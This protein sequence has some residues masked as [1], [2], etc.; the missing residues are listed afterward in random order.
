[1]R[2]KTTTPPIVLKK[3][4]NCPPRSKIGRKAA[5]VV[6]TPKITGTDTSIVPSIAASSF[7][8]PFTSNAWMRSPTTI[9]SST[10]IPNTK[11][12]PMTV[13]ELIVRPTD[14]NID[15]APAIAIGMPA[16]TQMASLKRK[17]RARITRTSIRP[18]YALPA[19]VAMRSCVEIAESEIISSP[20]PS[21]KMKSLDAIQRLT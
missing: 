13:S 11:I 4:P 2:Q 1:M 3:A 8:N 15:S 16:A 18:V 6:S 14:G 12:K 21:G 5:I 20:I 7:E 10:I 9:A 17:N 19:T